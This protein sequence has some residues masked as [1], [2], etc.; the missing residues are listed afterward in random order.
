MLTE[1]GD[2]LAALFDPRP[3]TTIRWGLDRIEAL[4]AELGRPE[5]SFDALHIAGTNGK[6]STACF[7]ASML[8][9]GGTCTGLYTSPHLEDVRER[10]RVDG[11]W[12]EESALQSAAARVSGCEAAADCT[13]FEL[14]TALA[15]T[16]FAECGVEVAVVETGLG[17][18]LDATNVL[19]P[20]GTAITPI[21]LDHTEWLGGSL[22]AIA[23]E[24]AGIFKAGAP[25]CLGRIEPGPL[26]A[27]E[28]VARDVGA[29]VARLGRDAEV[30]EVA[31]RTD[32]VETRFRYASRS[33]PGGVW[34]ATGLPGRYQADNAAL[35]LLLLDCSGY[36]PEESCAR[37]GIGRARL[38]GRFE[39][40]P[41]GAGRPG[42]VFD[43]AHNPAAIR[44]LCETVAEL[45]L[46]RPLV[47]VAGM[48]ADKDWKRT[49][50]RLA[51]DSDTMILTRSAVPAERRWDPS[52]ASEWLSRERSV[53]SIVCPNVAEAV[54]RGL[55]LAG[56]GTLLIT[57]S[58]T[59][60]GEARALPALARVPTGDG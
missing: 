33:R 3:A 32:P 54:G 7:A 56:A 10:F 41:P 57:G 4:L 5:R 29:P 34:L 31:V 2:A 47:A 45:S 22:E 35:A 58:A 8:E 59:T 15:F 11:A 1:G 27:L 53:E 16:C 18:R 49:L 26:A 36:P 51:L 60:V 55:T 14:A 13:Y 50:A 46:P 39:V 23:R 43:I 52:R 40:R 48:L 44:V 42:C 21:G 30:S 25:A 24:K 9:D 19:R 6:G 17:G 12:V 28:Q 37:R 20:A 38:A